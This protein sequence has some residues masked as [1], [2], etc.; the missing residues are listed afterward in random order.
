MKSY[1]EI[2]DLVFERR[3]QYVIAQRKKKKLLAGVGATLCAVSLLGGSVW[4][5]NTPRHDIPVTIAPDDDAV[6][7]A[8]TAAPTEQNVTSTTVDTLTTNTTTDGGIV[9]PPTTVAPSK[10]TETGAPTAGK[11]EPPTTTVTTGSTGFVTGYIPPIPTTTQPTIST[12]SDRLLI[13]GDDSDNHRYDESTFNKKERYITPA[14]QRKMKEYK[15]KDVLYAVIVTLPVTNE[16]R[17]EDFWASTEELVQ[18]RKEYRDVQD[19]FKEEALL[20]NPTWDGGNPNHI[21]VWTDTMRANYEYWLTL[22]KK[23]QE[24]NGQ[25]RADYLQLVLNQR[26]EVLKDLC[27]KEPVVVTCG[28]GVYGAYESTY[29]AELTAEAINTLAAQGGYVF[30]LASKD[31]TDYGFWDFDE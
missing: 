18:F 7:T 13:T 5:L 17:N 26:F 9:T 19:A 30:R 10:P 29:Y 25:P 28:Q 6:T 15:N 21:E 24:L 3:E 2:A 1:R 23:E 31:Q 12:G 11:T 22:V 16:D 14:L 4:Y 8:V 20:H 27:D